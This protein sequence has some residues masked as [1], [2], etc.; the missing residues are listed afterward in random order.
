MS[1]NKNLQNEALFF[2]TF[3]NKLLK[4]MINYKSDKLNTDIIKFLT[5]MINIFNMP[6]S[7]KDLLKDYNIRYKFFY[8]DGHI[9]R[10]LGTFVMLNL[11]N[12]LSLT[13]EF[14]YN[15]YP[16]I[17]YQYIKYIN[18]CSFNL[19]NKIYHNYELLDFLEQLFVQFYV[20]NNDDIN[21]I[22]S[23]NSINSINSIIEDTI[24][25]IKSKRAYKFLLI[26]ENDILT[27]STI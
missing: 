9:N 5:Y 18:L 23:I 16:N 27:I 1:P 3:L 19:F 8:K 21:S 22:D 14:T 13:K 10:Q 2:K 20:Y 26:F 24:N 6:K 25:N 4:D 17:Y 15:N 11:I 7:E 12:K